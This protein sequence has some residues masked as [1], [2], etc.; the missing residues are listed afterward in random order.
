MGMI[1]KFA[2]CSAYRVGATHKDLQR[3]FASW[4]MSAE[5]PW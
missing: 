4:A 5:S 2:S 1:W 3:E